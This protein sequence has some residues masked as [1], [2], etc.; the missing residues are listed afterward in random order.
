MRTFMMGVVFMGLLSTSIYWVFSFTGFDPALLEPMPKLQAAE[1]DSLARYEPSSPAV[2][3]AMLA[4]AEVGKDDIVFDLG[5]GDG[6]VVIA[7]ARAT[8]ARGICVEMQ[9][10]LIE[11]SRR[12]AERENV[13]DRVQFIQQDLLQ[14]DIS[15]AT[16]VMLYL[17][18][19]ANIMLRPKLFKELKPGSR[20][21]S[22]SHNMGDWK[23][24]REQVADDHRIYAW[25]VPASVDGTWNLELKGGKTGGN[26]TAEIVQNFQEITIRLQNGLESVPI[27]QATL[28]GGQI[29]FTTSGGLGSLSPPIEFTGKAT[30]G[31]LRGSFRSR[32]HSGTWSAKRVK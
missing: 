17:S 24:D 5:S 6:R 3:E 11:E 16:V 12:N 26:Y 23:P 19:D 9:T 32:G 25:V 31:G 10:D 8:G 30:G 29:L 21:V 14:A 7:A 22:H 13:A 28:T 27:N 18:P 2:V 15:S 20:I 1:P 4:L